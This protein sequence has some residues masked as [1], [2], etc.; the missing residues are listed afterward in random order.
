M[1]IRIPAMISVIL[2]AGIVI[3]APAYAE[4]NP[5][6]V[7]LF[8]PAEEE[9]VD[10]A[11]RDDAY[12]PDD[13]D[14][15]GR[16]SAGVEE[17]PP[18][19]KAPPSPDDRLKET[20]A[21]IERMK[22]EAEDKAENLAALTR[23][24]ASGEVSL[25]AGKKAVFTMNGKDGR[26]QTTAKLTNLEDGIGIETEK[27]RYE[28]VFDQDFLRGS[29]DGCAAS[30]QLV[31]PKEIQKGGKLVLTPAAFVGTLKC[32]SETRT[33]IITLIDPTR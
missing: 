27:A 6:G 29:I 13:G 23:E 7:D 2:I 28:V 4:E 1:K 15:M 22:L 19:E 30:F 8:D 11:Y 31:K 3:G 5:A 26:T 9:V 10:Y 18:Q 21:R 14:E 25:F 16:D 24:L 12:A 33:A 32:A 17:T 20:Q